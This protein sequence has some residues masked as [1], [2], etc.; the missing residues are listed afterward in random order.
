M[1]VLAAPCGSGRRLGR[2]HN[3]KVNILRE[4]V[5][6]LIR[7]KE[8][9]TIAAAF[10]EASSRKSA[11]PRFAQPSGAQSLRDAIR[12]VANGPI[13]APWA[14]PSRQAPTTQLA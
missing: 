7:V 10:R 2:C 9:Q 11:A 12:E 13:L 3:R 4:R 8:M 6:R 5:G 1:K 14:M